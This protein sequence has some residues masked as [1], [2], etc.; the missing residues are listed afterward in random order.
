MKNFIKN[1]RIL[2]AIILIDLIAIIAVVFIFIQQNSKSA[3]LDILVTPADVTIK[4]NNK[5]YENNNS[6]D[7]KPGI[8]NV[9]ISMEDMVTKTETLEIKSN[10]FTRLYTYLL[11]N[12]NSFNYYKTHLQDFYSLKQIASQNDQPA[13]EFITWADHA[14]SI[15]EKLPLEYYERTNNPI[16][17]YIDQS[18]YYCEEIV[19]LSAYTS[20]NQNHTNQIVKNLIQNAGFNLED[21]DIEIENSN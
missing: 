12:N 19:C 21:Y 18:Q 15:T 4:I 20:G 5:V 8:Y 11:D 17:V 14:Y 2:S 7:L 13:Q 3:T 6:Y 9:E 1:H 10:S 16:A